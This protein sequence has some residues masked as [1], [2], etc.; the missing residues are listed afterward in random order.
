MQGCLFQGRWSWGAAGY[1]NSALADDGCFQGQG[2]IAVDARQRI[3]QG[4]GSPQ[5]GFGQ[6]CLDLEHHSTKDDCP[7]IQFP[8]SLELTTGHRNNLFFIVTWQGFMSGNRSMEL[9]I[10]D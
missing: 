2:A 4:P 3:E 1:Q 7:G 9:F 10:V 5:S 6:S 8:S